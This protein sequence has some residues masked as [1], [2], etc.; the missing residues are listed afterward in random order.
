MFEY[1]ILLY[2]LLRN[3]LQDERDCCGF[4]DFSF[5]KFKFFYLRTC[6]VATGKENTVTREGEENRRL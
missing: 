1:F 2:F 4:K 5:A 3:D 6:K